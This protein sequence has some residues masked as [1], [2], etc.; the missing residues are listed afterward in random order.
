MTRRP[1]PFDIGPVHFIG[2]GM[3]GI[4]EI[5]L[6]IGYT[7][8]GVGRSLREDGTVAL[9]PSG[10]VGAL[11]GAEAGLGVTGAGAF[12]SAIT[13][14]GV[15]GAGS[16]GAGVAETGIATGDGACGWGSSRSNVRA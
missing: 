14:A 16:A 15:V 4:A 1:V 5:M 8:Q 2:I 3:S 7:V 12:G 6:R 10:A 11:A 13:G 9:S